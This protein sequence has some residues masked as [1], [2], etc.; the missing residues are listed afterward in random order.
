[1][2]PNKIYIDYAITIISS[3]GFYISNTS[4]STMFTSIIHANFNGEHDVDWN[5]VD[6]TTRWWFPRARQCRS[7]S[8]ISRS[9]LERRGDGGAEGSWWHVP[10][11]WF[12]GGAA[13]RSSVEVEAQ[14][15]WIHH[16][17]FIEVE[18]AK[19]EPTVIWLWRCASPP[20]IDE[21]RW[22]SWQCGNL[23]RNKMVVKP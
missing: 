13:Q 18:A 4:V 22:R 9:P 14:Q 2:E 20:W 11:R 5:K 12:P 17:S 16:R 10:R 3:S 8:T 6:G 7:G 23:R 19:R 21:R 1:M 15:E